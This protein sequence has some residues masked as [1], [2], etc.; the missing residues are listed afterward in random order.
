MKSW[1]CASSVD[2]TTSLCPVW[3][4]YS[5]PALSP[6]PSV[7]SPCSL[8]ET[9]ESFQRSF[10]PKCKAQHHTS[11]HEENQLYPRDVTGIPSLPS[12][13]DQK[14]NPQRVE[15]INPLKEQCHF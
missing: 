9:L 15:P 4:S 5:G 12:T 13:A 11:H 14:M 3:V 1:T 8:A 6:A 2:R 7:P 10:S